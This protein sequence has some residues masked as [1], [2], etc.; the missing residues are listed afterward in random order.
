MNLFLIGYRCTGKSSVGKC[1][2]KRLGWPFIDLDVKLVEEEGMTI[3]EIVNRFG[4]NT[5]REM[6]K[7]L[8]ERVCHLD[9]HVVAAGGGAILDEANVRHMRQS[10]V[11]IWLKATIETIRRRMLLDE[12]T[13]VQRPSLTRKGLVEEIEHLLME[14]HPLYARAMDFSVGTDSA[15]IEE[16][17]VV[18]LEKLEALHPGKFQ[19]AKLN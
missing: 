15:G 17:T 4:W 2:S 11:L 10:G 19:I 8:M 14:R 1:L 3:S 12:A 6:E 18:I 5:F 16:L 13:Q 9:R 7:G